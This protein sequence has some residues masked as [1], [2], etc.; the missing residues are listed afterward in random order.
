M[1]RESGV[2][3]ICP[4]GEDCRDCQWLGTFYILIMSESQR[5]REVQLLEITA[6]LKPL[7]A[8]PIP[9]SCLCF[10]Q[11]TRHTLRKAYVCTAPGQPY[12]RL[13]KDYSITCRYKASPFHY[14]T[15]SYYLPRSCE[16]AWR[17]GHISSALPNSN[18]C[19]DRLVMATLHA[20]LLVRSPSS[21]ST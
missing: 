8:T 5:I 18:T 15:L 21:I 6:Y 7:M 4:W 3:D 14:Q 16:S 12:A 2:S 1:R 19:L 20:P 17:K 10:M 11:D 13:L 9:L